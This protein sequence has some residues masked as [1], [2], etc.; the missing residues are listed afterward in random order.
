M[1]SMIT[2]IQVVPNLSLQSWPVYVWMCMYIYVY[3]WSFFLS[4]FSLFLLS[5]VKTVKI[6][7]CF[8]WISHRH[9]TF[10]MAQPFLAPPFNLPLHAV[11]W[12]CDFSYPSHRAAV[13]ELSWTPLQLPA[14]TLPWHEVLHGQWWLS[15][16]LP[17][18]PSLTCMP[19]VLDCLLFSERATALGLQVLQPLPGMTCPRFFT[20]LHIL[21]ALLKC[22]HLE[23]AW[24]SPPW[25]RLHG[26]LHFSLV[27]YS[28]QGTIS[29]CRFACLPI[30]ILH[31]P[32]MRTLLCPSVTGP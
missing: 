5:I 2:Y 4:P 19:A 29:F 22:Y 3:M 20:Q 17:P 9:L 6:Q 13:P 24:D 27:L 21:W 26:F 30:S 7:E 18:S 12:D 8:T 23:K 28:L 14:N 15:S 11:W 31:P 10:N 1:A 25:V 32:R 16:P